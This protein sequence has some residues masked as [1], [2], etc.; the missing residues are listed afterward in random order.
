MPQLPDLLPIEMPLLSVDMVPADPNRG[1]RTNIWQL[2]TFYFAIPTQSSSSGIDESPSSDG[3]RQLWLSA[4][5]QC[6]R[7]TLR[8]MS[9]PSH[10]KIYDLSFDVEE[11]T[12][13]PISSM[14]ASGLP[15]PKSPSLQLAETQYGKGNESSEYDASKLEREE[16]G[17]WS[18][19]FQQVLREIY[20]QD[21]SFLN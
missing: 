2:R 6:F 17:W 3:A 7:F 8:L 15:F 18:L 16:R 5:Q 4:F 19:R 20:R 14:A 12:R 11:D 9:F 10:S 1:S 21:E 13:H